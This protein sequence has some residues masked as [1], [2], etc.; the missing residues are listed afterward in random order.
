MTSVNEMNA[1]IRERERIRGKIMEIEVDMHE[2]GYPLIPR[3]EVLAI[4][5][6]NIMPGD[7]ATEPSH[8]D[9]E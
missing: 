9:K 7:K 3:G 2:N 4:L 5:S 6:E 8:D 1:I